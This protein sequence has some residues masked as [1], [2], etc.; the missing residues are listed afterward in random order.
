MLSVSDILKL[1]DKAPIW[2]T[3]R[4]TPARIAALEDR[5]AALEERGGKPAHILRCEIC[6]EPA[7]VTAIRDHPIFGEVGKKIRTVTCET[8]HEVDYDWMPGKDE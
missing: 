2:R 5:V 1:L 4:E 7:K 6:G 8:G 3:L